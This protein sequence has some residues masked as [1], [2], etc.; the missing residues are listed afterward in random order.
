MHQSSLGG[1]LLLMGNKIHPLWQTPFLPL[2][3]LLAAILC[4]IAFLT[5]LLLVAS[6]RYGRPVDIVILRDLGDILSWVSFVFLL[7]QFA[8]LLWRKQLAAAFAFDA[9]SLLFLLETG[10]ILVPAVV[11][12]LTIKHQIREASSSCVHSPAPVDCCTVTSPPRSRFFRR[13][14]RFTSRR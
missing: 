5:V 13:R 14:M 12:R 8:D 7:L 6:L 9:M 3:Y 11:L 4:G 1:L 10:L 2:L